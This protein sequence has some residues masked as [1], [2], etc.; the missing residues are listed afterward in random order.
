M[1]RP[2]SC[3]GIWQPCK[4][5]RSLNVPATRGKYQVSSSGAKPSGRSCGR[6]I[7]VSSGRRPLGFARAVGVDQLPG[8]GDADRRIVG[9]ERELLRVL[10]EVEQVRVRAAEL[11]L[12]VHAER[13]VPD[14]PASAG[15]AQLALADQ[16]QL[17]GVLVADG[18]PERAVGLQHA[19]HGLPSTAAPVEI[20][21]VLP[22]VVVDVVL[23]ADVERRIGKGQIDAAGLDFGEPL[24]CNRLGGPCRSPAPCRAP[25]CM[26]DS[27]W[28]R[29]CRPH[30]NSS[31]S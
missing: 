30:G 27:S 31:E 3:S 17:G 25:P 18:Q 26:R 7:Q 4:P 13:V 8:R 10:D 20:L 15:E 29:S 16:L 5:A 28:L 14:D 22:A 9:V 12:A 1:I 24:R 11:A 19:A 2:S 6:R 23:V 21:V